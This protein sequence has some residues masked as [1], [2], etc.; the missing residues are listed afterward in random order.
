MNAVDRMGGIQYIVVGLI[1]IYQWILSPILGP[2]CRFEPTCSEYA[3]E[4]IVAHGLIRG[5]WL[6]IRRIGRCHPLGESG[7]DPVPR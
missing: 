6:G 2:A 7:Y 4:A 5:A 1:R 3:S